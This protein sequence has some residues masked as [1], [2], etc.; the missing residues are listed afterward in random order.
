MGKGNDRK[1]TRKY[2]KYGEKTQLNLK[3]F[4][5]VFQGN[6]GRN[7]DFVSATRGPAKAVSRRTGRTCRVASFCTNSTRSTFNS[8]RICKKTGHFRLKSMKNGYRN[9]NR[10]DFFMN[11]LSIHG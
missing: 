5:F 3:S 2:E 9:C 6:S 4:L 8:G 7:G 10:G 11:R 1:I